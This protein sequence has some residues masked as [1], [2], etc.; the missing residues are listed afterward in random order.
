MTYRSE[1]ETTGGRND[2]QDAEGKAKGEE[3]VGPG[4]VKWFIMKQSRPKKLKQ[5]EKVERTDKK[6]HSIKLKKKK[7]KLK[8]DGEMGVTIID[9]HNH[10][11]HQ[12][13]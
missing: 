6:A 13:F 8:V 5:G 4:V 11:R 12:A 9:S 1:P 2:T 10:E 7:K 3:E